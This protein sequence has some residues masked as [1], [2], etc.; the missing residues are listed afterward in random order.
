MTEVCS[1]NELIEAIGRGCSESFEEI[2][3]RYSD[4]AYSLAT[5]FTKNQQ[6]AEEVL[7][8]VFTTVYRKVNSFEGKSSF[9]SWLYR[10]TVNAS[11]MKIRKRNQDKSMAME[12]AVADPSNSLIL[13]TDTKDNADEVTARKELLRILEEAVQDLPD[14]YRPVFILRD[15][16]GLTSKEVSNILKLSVPAVKSRLHRSRL[17]LRRKLALTYK[18]FGLSQSPEKSVG[19][20]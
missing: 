2:V 17:I 10:V 5:R 11:L 15:I 7:Q 4:K 18:E 3:S 19:N 12:D 6:D 20:L 1:D 9:S 13:K 8:D 16:D 14:E